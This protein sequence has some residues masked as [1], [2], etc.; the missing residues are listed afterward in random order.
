[1]GG[2]SELNGLA[3]AVRHDG[4]DRVEL[5]LVLRIFRDRPEGGLGLV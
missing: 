4:L 2:F 1:M 3:H 5:V